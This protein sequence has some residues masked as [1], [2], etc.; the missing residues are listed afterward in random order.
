MVN[1][2]LLFVKATVENRQRAGWIETRGGV[3][4]ENTMGQFHPRKP[5]FGTVG[6]QR[7]T[8]DVMFSTIHAL[9]SV[10]ILTPPLYGA[11]QKRPLVSRIRTQ[12]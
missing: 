4:L 8:E 1:N 3:S 7:K 9:F 2:L 12:S 6:D 11:T 10:Q 5:F